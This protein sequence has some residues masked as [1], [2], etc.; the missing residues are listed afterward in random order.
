[1]DCAAAI[2][3]CA[4]FRCHKE[5]LSAA[6][7]G[8][9]EIAP[10][11][12]DFPDAVFCARS[13]QWLSSVRKTLGRIL[14]PMGKREVL[15]NSAQPAPA[16]CKHQSKNKIRIGNKIKSGGRACKPDSVPHANRKTARMRGDHSSRSRFAP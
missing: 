5:F 1:M 2:P 9:P 14:R 6:N 4:Q 12:S 11:L 3:P 7:A 10:R 13:F 8:A 16:N 15:E